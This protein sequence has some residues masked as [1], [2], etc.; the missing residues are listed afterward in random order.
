MQ[1]VLELL[2]KYNKAMVRELL[3][4]FLIGKSSITP[5]RWRHFCVKHGIVSQTTKT[6]LPHIYAYHVGA[7]HKRC[8]ETGDIVQVVGTC[9]YTRHVLQ[10]RNGRNQVI[11]SFS[12]KDI[13]LP[14]VMTLLYEKGDI[15][16]GIIDR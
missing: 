9:D 15:E 16:D 13:E 7:D 5:A 8:E 12:I 2:Q 6:I 4:L 14:E 10:L 11:F 3:D 1:S